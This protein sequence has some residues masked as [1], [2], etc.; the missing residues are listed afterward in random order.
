MRWY[1]ERYSTE[2][3]AEPD[4]EQAG[5]IAESLENW[6]TELFEAVFTERRASQ[7]FNQFQFSE[8]GER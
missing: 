6:G 5:R 8:E 4:D 7:I 1:L 2:Y 3:T